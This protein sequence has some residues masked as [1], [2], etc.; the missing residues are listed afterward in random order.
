[1]SINPRL[2]MQIARQVKDALREAQELAQPAASQ[3][4]I[5]A[6]ASIERQQANDRSSMQPDGITDGAAPHH[7]SSH[8][9]G[10]EETDTAATG[11][12]DAD[13]MIFEGEQLSPSEL[14]IAQ[15]AEQ[16]LSIFDPLQVIYLTKQLYLISTPLSDVQSKSLHSGLAPSSSR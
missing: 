4:D 1:M 14:S 6:A 15:A 2:I 11:A 13:M 8:M 5:S 9:N 12:G 10:S 7:S 3:A 16:V